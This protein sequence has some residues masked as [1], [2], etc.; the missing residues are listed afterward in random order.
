MWQTLFYVPAEI[1]GYP[2]FGF[3]LLLAV[4]AV[5]SIAVLGWQAWRHGVGPELWG[6]LPI[7]LLFGAAIAFVL[8]A[9]SEPEGLPIR[10]YGTMM[11]L[12]VLAGTG[13]AIRRARRVGIDPDFIFSLVFWMV[14]P[15]ILGARLFY[16]IRFWP[17]F[18]QR[19]T[20]GGLGPFL[21]N[22]IDLTRGGLVVYGSFFGG[23]LGAWLFLRKHRVPWLAVADLLAPSMMLG[24]A[25]GRVGCLLNG[26][27]YGEVC[28]HAWAV[29][30][31]AG[32]APHYSPPYQAQIERGQMY[33]FKLS[34]DPESPPKVLSIKPQSAAE[35]AGLKAGDVLKNV[36]G[37]AIANT[38]QAYWALAD[39]FVHGQALH[40]ERQGQP[41]LAVPAIA[42]PPRTL[43]VHPTQIYSTID[44]L[45]LCLLLLAY[46]PF[47]RREGELFALMMTVYP[48]TRFLIESLRTDE[49]AVFGTGLSIAQ[50]ISMLL[51]L[52]AVGLWIYILRQPK[53]LLGKKN[54]LV[55][56][57]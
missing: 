23:V 41:A 47:R 56:Q 20:D 18:A 40:I 49:S 48:T 32:K 42:P 30:F 33:G 51:L 9:I 52:F 24:L 57:S 5:V 21:G 13:L 8:P 2:V 11:L 15:G 50:N 31:P 38:G 25:I 43:P 35:K 26:C 4:W 12:A 34:T 22:L 17:E 10:G 28:N 44:A 55:S 53:G 14:V 6:Y 54:S 1:H 45:L 3:G 7:L 37:Y 39:A 29:T 19:W 16:I 46:D 27:C 36:N